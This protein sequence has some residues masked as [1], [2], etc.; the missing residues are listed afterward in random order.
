M[1]TTFVS[2]AGSRMKSVWWLLDKASRED[3]ILAQLEH[4]SLKKI[5]SFCAGRVLVYVLPSFYR[6][7]K[8]RYPLDVGG[9]S[10][11][12]RVPTEF[13]TDSLWQ[14]VGILTLE[15]FPVVVDREYGKWVIWL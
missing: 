5:K 7:L 15:V 10:R 3:I 9:V 13:G 14:A 1:V 4:P 12:D 2:S 8:R 6:D 11:D